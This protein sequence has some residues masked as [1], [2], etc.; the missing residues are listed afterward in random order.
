MNCPNCGA[1]VKGKT[2]EYCGTSFSDPNEVN[3]EMLYADSEIFK[4]VRHYNLDC[5]R[6]K[7]GKLHREV[8]TFE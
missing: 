1:V 3:I 5:Y 4:V 6:D 8:F 7:D 2:C